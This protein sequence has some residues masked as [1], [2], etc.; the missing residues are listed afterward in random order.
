MERWQLITL[1]ILFVAF[2]AGN[3]IVQIKRIRME[4]R[5]ID[6]LRKRANRG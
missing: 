1:C 2:C 3:A 5:M 4:R 6:F